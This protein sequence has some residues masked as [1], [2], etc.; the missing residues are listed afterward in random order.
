MT[1]KENDA[2][3]SKAYDGVEYEEAFHIKENKV[4][5]LNVMMAI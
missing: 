2:G 4:S 5:M 3:E 1:G